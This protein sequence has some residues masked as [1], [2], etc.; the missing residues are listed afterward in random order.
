VKPALI[1]STV[2]VTTK[3]SENA[4]KASDATTASVSL[5]EATWVLRLTKPVTP[6]DRSIDGDP[7]SGAGESPATA[8]KLAKGPGN[9]AA[10][11]ARNRRKR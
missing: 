3:Q 4:L 11:S 9:I 10:F 8:K 5:R 7:L 1:D 2:K 6:G